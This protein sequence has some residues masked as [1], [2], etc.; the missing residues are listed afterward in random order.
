MRTPVS[1]LGGGRYLVADTDLYQFIAALGL[2][3]ASRA[4]IQARMQ[5]RFPEFTWALVKSGDDFRHW[6]QQAKSINSNM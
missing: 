1:S 3:S 5:K 6:I 4:D 2:R